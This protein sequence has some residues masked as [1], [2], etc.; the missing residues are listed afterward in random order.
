MHGYFPSLNIKGWQ[1][2]ELRQTSAVQTVLSYMKQIQIMERPNESKEKIAL[3]SITQLKYFNILHHDFSRKYLCH[4]LKSKFIPRLHCNILLVQ[5]FWSKI[6][7]LLKPDYFICLTDSTWETANLLIE[8]VFFG[9]WFLYT[10]V[11]L[12]QLW[13]YYYYGSRQAVEYSSLSGKQLQKSL[14]KSNLH[15]PQVP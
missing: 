10:W 7:E 12:I 5:P 15:G 11:L 9:I 3:F 13:F 8:K 1:G 14:R 4:N 6:L 2:H